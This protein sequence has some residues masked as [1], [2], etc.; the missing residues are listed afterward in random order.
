MLCS[1]SLPSHSNS[2]DKY[3][4][5]VIDQYLPTYSAKLSWEILRQHGQKQGWAKKVWFKGHVPSHA[6]LMWVAHLNRLPTRVRIA[7]W[8]MQVVKSCCICNHYDELRDHLFLR[9]DFSEH[10]WLLITKRLGYR[11]FR[12]HTWTALIEWLDISDIYCPPT[13][14][15]LVIQATVYNLWAE[16]NRKLHS[17]VSSTPQVIF[18]AI[19]R[20][21]RNTIHARKGRK[22]FRNMMHLWLRHA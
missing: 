8:G 5:H 3:L 11:P 15:C 10:L 1:V 7:N 17:Q 13:L 19:D 6:F 20:L 21:I 12:F 16:R 18:K 9:C 4:W 2:P 22:N 14:K